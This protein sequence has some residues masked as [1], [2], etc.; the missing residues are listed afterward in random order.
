VASATTVNRPGPNPGLDSRRVGS[1]RHYPNARATRN[2]SPREE[3]AAERAAGMPAFFNRYVHFLQQRALA[4]W[5]DV[6]ATARVLDIGCGVGHWTRRLAASGHT[7]VGFDRSAAMIDVAR[8]CAERDG[9]SHRCQFFVGDCASF[10]LDRQFDCI[11]GVTILQHMLDGPRLAATLINIT[12][13]LAPSGRVVLLETAPSSATAQCASATFIART[14][15]IYRD[16]FEAVGLQCLRVEGV[17]PAP[18]REWVLPKFRSMPHPLATLMMFMAT[19]A[20]SPID[21][22]TPPRYRTIAAHKIFVL[23]RA[24]ARTAS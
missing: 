21:V 24:T 1:T 6:P 9:L 19:V 20:G 23:A 10:S 17:D 7:V 14:E 12:R 15:R 18:F 13:H 16:A 22:L 4:P 11:V 5:L 8:R 2:A 3:F